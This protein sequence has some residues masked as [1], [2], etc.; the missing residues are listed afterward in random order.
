MSKEDADDA[1]C[2]ADAVKNGGVLGFS[3]TS[4]LAA[5][6]VAA[7]VRFFRH[8]PLILQLSI[9]ALALAVVGSFWRGMG[10]VRRSHYLRAV[11][12]LDRGEPETADEE[13][14][15]AMGWPGPGVEETEFEEL[16]RSIAAAL[17]EEQVHDEKGN[18]P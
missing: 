16:R 18:A 2:R 13:I 8:D 10:A 4:I 15:Y 5:F 7:V 1:L 6:A 12:F 3:A 17:A 9:G 11:A 14:H